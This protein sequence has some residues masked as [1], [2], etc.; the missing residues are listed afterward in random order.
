MNIHRKIVPHAGPKA[1]RFSTDAYFELAP[2]LNVRFAKTELLD[3]VIYEMPTDGPVTR[4][5]NRVI[6]KWLIKSLPDHLAVTSHQTLSLGDF[7]APSP[8]HYLFAASIDDANVTG[9]NVLL[10]IEVSDSTLD[11][12]LGEKARAYAEHGVREYW[13]I[14]PN[15]RRVFVHRLQ[16]DRTFATPQSLNAD[17]A[18]E[19]SLIP[20]LRL[21]LAD[22]SEL[23]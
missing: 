4:R 2:V 23:T 8:D 14:D 5:W 21:R 22:F 3:G 19:A 15:E 10:V 17:E 16:A 18:V 6:A 20:G 11:Y 12:D 1:V 13:V 7:W 9:A